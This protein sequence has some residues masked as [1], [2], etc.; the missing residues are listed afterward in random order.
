MATPPASASKSPSSAALPPCPPW[1]I[2]AVPA[3]ASASAA[4]VPRDGA[5]RPAAN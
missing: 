4:S 1:L 5:P 3:T 2:T